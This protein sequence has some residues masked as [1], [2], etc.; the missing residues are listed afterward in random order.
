[1]NEN[2]IAID[3]QAEQQLFSAALTSSPSQLASSEIENIIPSIDLPQSIPLTELAQ[4]QNELPKSVVLDPTQLSSIKA[5][6]AE[7][8]SISVGLNVKFDAEASYNK[9]TKKIDDLEQNIESVGNQNV[10]N[11]M[12][13]PK[14]EN[15][16]EEKP[17][18]DPTNLI[19]D[20]RMQRFSDIPSW[21]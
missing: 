13:Y 11:W 10:Q 17:S 5:T 9:L 20:D 18:V 12:P 6:M 1:M 7:T 21:A 14:A 16:F 19:F 8:A 2:E 4:Q 15:K 3:V